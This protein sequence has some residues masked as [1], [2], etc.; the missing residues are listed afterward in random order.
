MTLHHCAPTRNKVFIRPS[1]GGNTLLRLG[2]LIFFVALAS[3]GSA[4]EQCSIYSSTGQWPEGTTQVEAID[5]PTS[6]KSPLGL[7]HGMTPLEVC[8]QLAGFKGDPGEAEDTDPRLP[9]L[10]S[11]HTDFD[12]RFGELFSPFELSFSGEGAWLGSDDIFA[13]RI[14]ISAYFSAP[15]SGSQLDRFQLAYDFSD[16]SG[17]QPSIS[18]ILDQAIRQFGPYSTLIVDNGIYYRWVIDNG[19][20]QDNLPKASC[21]LSFPIWPLQEPMNELGANCDGVILLRFHFNADNPDRVRRAIITSDDRTLILR[22]S[23]IDDLAAQTH[24]KSITKYV[25][26]PDGELNVRSNPFIDSDI[27]GVIHNGDGVLV[28]ET[29]GNWSNIVAADELR[30]W[31]Y[32]SLLADIQTTPDHLQ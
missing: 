27:W 11:E 16:E 31:V 14:H 28:T 29:S 30:G 13:S 15:P 18:E 32:S 5:W 25:N 2:L 6:F 12:P 3:H 10:R 7:Q 1:N 23:L 22:S 19:V 8:N 9:A 4:D 26:S 17:P 20:L 24:A 21:P